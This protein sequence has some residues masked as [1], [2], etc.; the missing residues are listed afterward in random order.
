MRLH[1]L[2][3]VL[4]L[5][6]V[7]GVRAADEAKLKYT[8]DGND[9]VVSTQVT[10]NNSA[11]ALL[12]WTGG[13]DSAPTL[14]YILVQNTTAFVRSQKTVTVEWRLPGKKEADV[15]VKGVE[16]TQVNLKTGELQGFAEQMK[17]VVQ[18]G[19]KRGG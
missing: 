6:A 8:Q 19:E 16:G 2:V 15:K 12:T 18:A 17:K 3:G 14:R 7:T 5:G 10:A 1:A 13:D 9:L 11:H 4:V